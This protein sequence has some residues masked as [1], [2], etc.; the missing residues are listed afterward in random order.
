[1]ADNFVAAHTKSVHDF[2]AV[3]I[4]AAVHEHRDRQLQLVE[5]IYQPP[6]A[7]PVAIVAPG[8]IEDVRLRTAGAEFGAEP[9]AECEMLEIEAD[10]DG[11]PPSLRPTEVRPA[12][13]RAVTVAPVNGEGRPR[14]IRPPLRIPRATDGR[15]LPPL[16]STRRAPRQ[17]LGSLEFSPRRRSLP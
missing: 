17:S 16:R 7:D 9:F 2:R 3:V 12:P 10:I 4:D 11:K 14:A 6:D 5:Q 1:M 13:D 8:I 15:R